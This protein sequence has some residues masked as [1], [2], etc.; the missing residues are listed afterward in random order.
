MLSGTR[1]ALRSNKNEVKSWLPQGHEETTIFEWYRGYFPSDM[2][3]L[4]SWEGCTLDSPALELMAKKLVPPEDPNWDPNNPPIRFFRR[5][6]TGAD[7]LEE[8]VERQGLSREEAIDRLRGIVIGKDGRQTCLVLS[9]C[10]ESE[11]RW[12]A[13]R[14]KHERPLWFRL[15]PGWLKGKEP[16]EVARYEKKFLHAV[17]DQIR[18]VAEQECAIPPDALHLGGPPV[19]NVAIDVE[20]EKSLLR[21]A[22]VS[23]AVGLL[24]AWW[25]LRS[26]GL[27]LIVFTTALFTAGISMAVVRFTGASMNA[28]LLTMPSLV[29]VAAA[30]GAIHLANYYRDTVR[31][32][33]FAGAADRA[34][35]AAW[36]PLALATGTTA[37]GLAS[38]C[39]TDLVPIRLFG[40]YSAIGVGIGFLVVILYM[41]SLLE[42]FPVKNIL[43]RSEAEARTFDPGLSPKWRTVGEF[44]IRRNVWVTAACL[45]LMAWGAYGVSQTKTSVKL[46]RLFSPD[47]RI[48]QDYAW[49]EEKLGP[50][51]PMEVVIRVNRKACNIDLLERMALV[52]AVQQEIVKLPDVGSTLAAPT[53][54]PTL[55]RRPSAL[56]RRTWIVHL[57]RRRGDLREYL[58]T[59]EEEE[60]WRV[61]ARIAALTNLDYGEFVR[62]IQAA[63]EPVLERYREKGVQGIS[64]TYTG[65]V[66]LIYKAQSSML[67]GLVLNFVGDLILIGVAMVCLMRCL[68]AGLLLMLPA[69]FPLAIVFGAMGWMGVVI[70]VGTVM[71]P[72]VALGVT[73][74]DAIHFMLWCRHGQQ[75][76]MNKTQAIM[77]AYED[78]ARAIYQSWGVIGLGLFAFALSSFTPTQRFGY[79]MFA[80]LTASSI[81]NLVLLPALLAG[82]L[83]RNFWRQ[84]AKRSGGAARE[85]PQASARQS[86]QD[87]TPTAETAAAPREL[88]SHPPSEIPVPHLDPA[89]IPQP[90]ELQP[91]AVPVSPTLKETTPTTA[92]TGEC[93]VVQ[94]P[95]EDFPA[96]FQ[97]AEVQSAEDLSAEEQH[98]TIPLPLAIHGKE[99]ASRRPVRKQRT[100]RPQ[101]RG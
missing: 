49:L 29:Y 89:A 35:R 80:M 83:G 98:V 16:P 88:V 71:T 95:G 65:L 15:L 85:L 99:K 64:A 72:A 75:R 12:D 53:F 30:S 84:G 7:L 78:C 21:L 43:A 37:I 82:P 8:L 97:P 48:I 28:I 76:G 61:S 20:G 81:G 93:T 34:V 31:Q 101:T 56:E 51:V 70:D 19:D 57:E 42:L 39:V 47:A 59:T 86:A 92:H 5:V 17:I 63:V 77:F 33:G 69:L 9:V 10:Q 27:T 55:P 46:M 68:S 96:R 58:C 67:D 38:M 13:L 45:G 50:L 18:T 41:P 23:A 1:Q 2:F 54:A 4:V 100:P 11:A 62:D 73:V 40:L 6:V 74:D 94:A 90:L 91:T 3:V 44:I 25:C 79:L 60:L 36:L 32:H 66:P 26:W 24:M 22:G 87:W 14:A 52:A